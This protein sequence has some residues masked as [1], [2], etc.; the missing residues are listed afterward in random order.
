MEVKLINR[1]RIANSSKESSITRSIRLSESESRQPTYSQLFN[2]NFPL[3]WISLVLRIGF[4]I[5]F[6]QAFFFFLFSPP[7]NDYKK[8][9]KSFR[10]E[11]Q[12]QIARDDLNTIRVQVLCKCI[13]AQMTASKEKKN[14][15]VLYTNIYSACRNNLYF[16]SVFRKKILS[17]FKVYPIF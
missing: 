7:K 3:Y 4:L 15:Q 16:S 9:I 11:L 8:I 10:V 2:K 13:C 1:G 17:F 14:L 12:N 6:F 5:N